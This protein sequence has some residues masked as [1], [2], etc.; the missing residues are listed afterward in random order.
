[1]RDL[2]LTKIQDKG[3]YLY[4]KNNVIYGYK[5]LLG[6]ISPILVHISLL[7][8]LCASSLSA[9]FNFKAQ[10][11]IPKGELFHIQNSI[12]LGSL[13]SLSGVST[14]VNDFWVEYENNRVH[15]FYSNLSLLDTFGHEIKQQTI[16]V[17][18]P[19]R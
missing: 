13:T 5:G 17:N 2:I 12:K 1:M 15:Q 11:I 9:F 3:F 4:Q 10:E 7:I 6:R 16:S 18:N 8:I 19:L 14:R